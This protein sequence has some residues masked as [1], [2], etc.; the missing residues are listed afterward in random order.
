VVIPFDSSAQDEKEGFQ[1]R[2][3]R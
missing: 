2:T 3:R 1:V